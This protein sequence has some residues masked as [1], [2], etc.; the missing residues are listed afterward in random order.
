MITARVIILSLTV[1]RLLD[2]VKFK[3][4]GIGLRLDLNPIWVWWL[5]KLDGKRS[6]VTSFWLFMTL[7]TNNILTMLDNCGLKVLLRDQTWLN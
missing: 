4:M 5:S 7:E 6:K 1:H 3:L 2:Y